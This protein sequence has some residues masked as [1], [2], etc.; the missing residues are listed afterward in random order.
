MNTEIFGWRGRIL[1]IDLYNSRITELETMDCAGRFHG[2][3]GIL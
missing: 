3:R 1:R 2:G